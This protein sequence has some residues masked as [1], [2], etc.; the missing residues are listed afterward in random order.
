MD[1]WVCWQGSP[2]PSRPGKIR[3][4]PINPK[5]GGNAQSNNPDTWSSFQD[6]VAVSSK[7]SGIGFMFANG[8]WGV[9]I[10]EIEED[11]Q[12]YRSGDDKNIVSEFVHSLGSYAEYSVSGNGIHILCQ[13]ELPKGGRRKKNVEMYDTGRF[14][15]CTGNSCSDYSEVV[16]C[17]EPIKFLHEKYIGGGTVP[18]VLNQQIM[19]VNIDNEKIIDIALKSKNGAAFQALHSGQWAGL[20]P[21][22]SE[23]DLAFSNMLAFWT[24]ADINKM[25]E[26][27]RSSGLMRDK[28]NRKTG[29]STYG[30]NVLNRAI[31]DCREVF[32]PNMLDDGY[33]IY[34]GNENSQQ[35][36]PKLKKYAMDDTGNA[37]RFCENFG[38]LLRYSYVT[39]NWY[40]YDGRKWDFDESG[41]V[42]KIADDMLIEMKKE[43]ALCT[44]E[45]EEKAFM[46][47]LKYTR[48]SKGKKNFI[49]ESEHRLS[50]HV[51]DFD[52]RKREINTQNGVLNLRTGE[53][54]PHSHDQFLSRI[55]YVEYTDKI[56]CPGWI[57]FLND[58]FDSD[59]D[60]IKYIQK[61]V[62]Y[63]LT[64]LT[65]E[66]CVFFTYGNGR[67]GKSTFIDVTSS[68]MGDYATNIQPESI[69]VA[70][71]STGANSD[72]AR[73][74]GSR[75]VTTVEP[76]EGMRLNEGLIKQL[77]GGDKVTARFL[78]GKEFEFEPEFKLWVS[79]NH[80]PIIR[81]R[82]DGIWR[83]IHLI[84]FT[85]QIPKDKVDKNLKYKLKKELVGILDWAVVGCL[86]WQKEGLE[87]P[88]KVKA[89]VKEYQSEMDVVSAFLENCTRKVAHKDTKAIELYH[90][91]AQ[92]ADENN[93][94]KMSNTKFGKELG[95]RFEKIRM[96]YGMVYKGVE[97]NEDKKAY[98]INFA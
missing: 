78:Y 17:S 77:T 93:E 15:I 57:N 45:D 74:K 34:I 41:H 35:I 96:N 76:S 13:G 39:K 64:G 89:A 20:Y 10:D 37:D 91:Y 63:S 52:K 79:T 24:G 25:D 36:K 83:R 88:D 23:A 19:P 46:K 16:D 11:I 68:I 67:N 8:I 58:V 54:S 18:E 3:K 73:L 42:K 56:D 32:T 72:I 98:S 70:N 12:S 86:L 6:A 84:P 48:N 65:T 60:L 38:E 92:W 49:T 29:K 7:F 66:Q 21:S 5:T 9:D 80:K 2:D 62:G 1:Q 97:L 40:F 55:S 33:T 82:D 71:R 69:M 30:L 22:Q 87:K 90:A 28:W 61:A 81:G 75:F 59:Q 43:F 27:F 44:D 50:I 51:N 47:H 31:A 95:L 26:I 14:F 4:I 85:V 94:Y 53:L